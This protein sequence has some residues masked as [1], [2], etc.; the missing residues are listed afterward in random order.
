MIVDKGKKRIAELITGIESGSRT[1]FTHVRVGDGGDSTS[2]SQ[3]TLDSQ[4]STTKT[5]TP[6]LVG[7]TLI[8]EI[9]LLGSDLSSNIISELGIFDGTGADANMLCRVSFDPIGPI[10][11]SETLTFNFRVEIE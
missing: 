7:N 1:T 8:Y 5:V 6:I 9:E 3:T 10:T 11:A 2:M 4:V